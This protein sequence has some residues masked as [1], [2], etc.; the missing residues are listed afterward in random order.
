MVFHV[1]STD[2]N[3][4]RHSLKGFR[5]FNES[6]PPTSRVPTTIHMRHQR[7]IGQLNETQWT[8]KCVNSVNAFS[9][10]PLF[11]LEVCSYCI[12]FMGVPQALN[13]DHKPTML[14]ANWRA[15]KVNLR[16]PTLTLLYDSIEGLR[17]TIMSLLWRHE[18]QNWSNCIE[19]HNRHQQ[20]GQQLE[21]MNWEL[22]RCKINGKSNVEM[23]SR[24][25]FSSHRFKHEVVSLKSTDSA[26]M[27]THCVR[28]SRGV[29]RNTM[30][31]MKYCYN[32]Y[33]LLVYYYLSFRLCRLVS[34]SY[35][36]EG[37]IHCYLWKIYSNG[38][39]VF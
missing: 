34:W 27:C 11:V 6:R 14:L 8:K 28:S 32:Y 29:L 5:K 18:S 17:S 12:G 2:S 20:W 22:G 26:N 4:Q 7:K 23:G 38:V 24:P 21:N 16:A 35:S 15:F 10:F 9:A 39:I 33:Y 31:M 13:S 36:A 37:D 30:M 1:L 3:E 25:F 19:Q